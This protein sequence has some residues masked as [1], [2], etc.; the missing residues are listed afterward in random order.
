[1][2]SF[3]AAKLGATEILGTDIDPLA[4]RVARENADLNGITTDVLTLAQDS[5]PAHRVGHFRIIVANI[6][7]EVLVNLFDSNYDNPPL[8]EP[9]HDDGYLILSG[10]L[11][12][13]I[14]MVTAAAIRHGFQ[15]I[16]TKQEGDWVAL[17]MKRDT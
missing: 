11:A 4:V 6:L 12:E 10:I 14:N 7:A 16:E 5:V 13:K 17:V 9:L 8:A 15:H 2:L 1:M 3:V